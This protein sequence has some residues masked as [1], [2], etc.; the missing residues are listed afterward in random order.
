MAPYN[1]ADYYCPS[2]YTTP[3][4]VTSGINYTFTQSGSACT[5]AYAA[6]STSDPVCNQ[7]TYAIC[8]P[9]YKGN[10]YTMQWFNYA[11]NWS[12]NYAI[13]GSTCFAQNYYSA[14]SG[15]P[16]TNDH[17]D[18]SNQLCEYALMYSSYPNMVVYATMGGSGC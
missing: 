13:S 16:I 14:Y 3:A 15:L 17:Y 8:A 6:V 2:T 9:T 10:T 4:P 12:V 1:G 11:P 18:T 5:A 7:A